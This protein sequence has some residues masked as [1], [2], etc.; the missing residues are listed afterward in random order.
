MNQDYLTV[1]ALRKVLESAS[2]GMGLARSVASELSGVGPLGGE[3]S[4][5]IL[6]GFP[7]PL[8]LRPISM[9]RSEEASILAS[10]IV[11]APRSSTTLVGRSGTALAGTL[12]KWIRAKESSRLQQK[13]LRFRSLI[14]SAILGA[15]TAMVASLGPLVS[16]LNFMA[17]VPASS[18]AVLLCCAGA[19]AGISSAML[20]LYM[21]GRGFYLNLIATLGAFT[22]VG[23]LAS[24]LAGMSAAGLWG[25]K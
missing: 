6:L 13:A 15:V 22:L 14:T 4:R 19:M 7:L 25:V 3:T 12:E 5:L 9:G 2:D 11:S 20:G 10:L 18:P 8:A 1:L 16:N 21:S 24:P 23:L 17:A